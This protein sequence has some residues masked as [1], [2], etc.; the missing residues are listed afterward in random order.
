MEIH[1]IEKRRIFLIMGL[2]FECCIRSI[3]YNSYCRITCTHKHTFQSKSSTQHFIRQMNDDCSK[4]TRK[5][6]D[7]MFV[8]AV[9]LCPMI[10]IIYSMENFIYMVRFNRSKTVYKCLITRFRTIQHTTNR[11]SVERNEKSKTFSQKK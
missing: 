8:L 7:V 1:L 5:V 3:S 10:F 6:N 2:L 11:I 4:P 9:S